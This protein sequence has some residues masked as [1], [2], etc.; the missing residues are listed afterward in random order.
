MS[1]LVKAYYEYYRYPTENRAIHLFENITNYKFEFYEEEI[2][3]I[4]KHWKR[5]SA[6]LKNKPQH[7][8]YHSK[9]LN[10]LPFKD[11]KKSLYTGGST[12][13]HSELFSF[14]PALNF[15]ISKIE[16]FLTNNEFPI[17]FLT[18]PEFCTYMTEP[19]KEFFEVSNVKFNARS[20]SNKD[21]FI[22]CDFRNPKSFDQF[23]SHLN[24]ICKDYEK[25][26]LLAWP[27]TFLNILG[28]HKF[29]DFIDNNKNSI[30]SVINT[31]CE[32]VFKKK[33]LQKNN[34][35]INDQMIDWSTGLNFYTCKHNKKHILPIFYTDMES[36]QRINLLNLQNVQ[37]KFADFFKKINFQ[38]CECGKISCNFDFYPHYNNQILEPTGGIF[39]DL[40]LAEK[41]NGNYCFLQI[42]QDIIY[43]KTTTYLVPNFPS[44]RFPD[45]E[46]TIK[47]TMKKKGINTDIVYNKG[48]VVGYRKR[49]FFWRSKADQI[50]FLKLTANFI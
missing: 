26:N 11:T 43:N 31:D 44:M 10:D 21:L 37:L 1:D 42:H 46:M 50:S 14:K 12:K 28:N 32:P 8:L 25:F 47:E 17:I 2:K 40:N 19:A 38:K 23:L 30:E 3:E 33:N 7:P 39:Q 36:K 16:Q 4:Y 29:T 41:L 9:N 22:E 18:P 45:D 24:E 35:P 27:Y 49:N 15:W 6:Y 48:F 20:K 13:G 5:F 34:I